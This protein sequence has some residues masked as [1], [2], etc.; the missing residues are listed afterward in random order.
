MGDAFNAPISLRAYYCKIWKKATR[1][2]DG[3]WSKRAAT[4]IVVS[5]IGLAMWGLFLGFHRTIESR[6]LAWLFVGSSLLFG[7]LG[8][9]VWCLMRAPYQIHLDD[10]AELGKSAS[11]LRIA[12]SERDAALHVFDDERY[13]FVADIFNRIST[14]DKKW[15]RDLL[16]RPL[17][18]GNTGR[19]VLLLRDEGIV[20]SEPQGGLYS[21]V[22]PL[23]PIIQRLVRES[24]I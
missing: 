6:T 10:Q 4:E 2:E 8:R 9:L 16:V 19:G 15:L 21:I 22:P 13:R 24:G 1:L 12:A 23:R 5:G 7:G 3:K 11:D 20:T 18:G 14:E 17:M